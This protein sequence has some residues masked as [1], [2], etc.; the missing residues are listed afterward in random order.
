MRLRENGEWGPTYYSTESV[1]IAAGMFIS[2]IHQMGLC[3][4]THTPSPMK[5]LGEILKRPNH[6]TAMLVLPVG[7]PKD[8]AKVPNIE[9]KDLGEISVFLE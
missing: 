4:L 8:G 1:G 2:A 7:Y 3:T 5:F 6:E 9:R